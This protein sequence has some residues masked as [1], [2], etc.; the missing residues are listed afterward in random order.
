MKKCQKCGKENVDE[1]QFCSCCGAGLKKHMYCQKCGRILLI[2]GAVAIILI[3]LIIKMQSGKSLLNEDR[4]DQVQNI[5]NESNVTKTDVEE[6]DDNKI[7]NTQVID[8]IDEYAES[9][10]WYITGDGSYD[11]YKFALAY[12][13]TDEIP[14]LLVFPGDYHASMVEVYTFYDNEVCNVGSFGSSGCITYAT[15]QNLI[16]SVYAGQG[17]VSYEYYS[18]QEGMAHLAKSIGYTDYDF[19]TE[20]EAYY[21][22]DKKVSENEYN[23][24]LVKYQNNRKWTEA[25]CYADGFEINELTIEEMINEYKVSA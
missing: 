10:Y 13:D 5:E 7:E 4:N 2:V 8:A 14:E 9:L 3:A 12:I 23:Q 22:D 25:S 6:L 19:E 16:S 15:K 24:E 17:S 1:A 18:I 20:K 11:E 21:I